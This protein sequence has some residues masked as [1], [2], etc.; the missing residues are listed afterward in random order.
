MP[1]PKFFSQEISEVKVVE[2]LEL[3]T[4][5]RA[6]IVETSLFFFTKRYFVVAIKHLAGAQWVSLTEEVEIFDALSRKIES[7]YR[8]AT[9]ETGTRQEIYQQS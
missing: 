6:T 2:Q 3:H 8:D 4:I 7:A 5:I 1:W 9:D